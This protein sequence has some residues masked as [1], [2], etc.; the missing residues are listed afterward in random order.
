VNETSSQPELINGVAASNTATGNPSRAIRKTRVDKGRR[1]KPDPT[2]RE[3]SLNYFAS[4]DLA[5]KERFIEDC[6]LILKF[7]QPAEAKA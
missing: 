5:G 7:S 4:L 2:E 3:T 1:R 6:E